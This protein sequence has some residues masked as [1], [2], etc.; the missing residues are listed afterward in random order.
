MKNRKRMLMIEQ[1]DQKLISFK[2]AESITRPE[3]GWINAIRKSLN[4]TLTQLG[5]RLNTTPQSIRGA[6]IREASGNITINALK[7]IADAMELKVIYAII[8][9][10]QSLEKLIESRAL[11]LATQIVL[12]T[13][14]SMRLED[15]ENTKARLEKAIK[16]KTTE[17]KE[18]L[19]KYLWD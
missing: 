8:P 18:E 11:A 5:T 16:E 1:L 3:K 9:K 10:D 13:S 2:K 17:I 6:E 12:R 14:A 4:I 15:Q 7:E 19:P